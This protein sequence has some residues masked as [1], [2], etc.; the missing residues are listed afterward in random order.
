MNKKKLITDIILFITLPSFAFVSY[1][2]YEFG[3]KKNITKKI[4]EKNSLD[5]TESKDIRKALREL[6]WKDLKTLKKY[7]EGDKTIELKENLKR[8]ID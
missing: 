6:S 8:I 5:K 4:T 2:I 7:L 3:Y 1:K